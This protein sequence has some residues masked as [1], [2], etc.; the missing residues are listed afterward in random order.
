MKARNAAR[1]LL[2][3]F[4]SEERRGRPGATVQAAVQAARETTSDRAEQ[5]IVAVYAEL[6]AGEPRQ[7]LRL[8]EE[9]GV[10]ADATTARRIRA[11]RA[12]AERLDK[13]WYPG[14]AGGEFGPQGTA[15]FTLPSQ[16]FPGDS[17]TMLVE[18]C[19]ALGPA[20]L[21]S[22][23]S[24]LESLIRKSAPPA[25]ALLQSAL[26]DLQLFKEVALECNA[27][28]S[29][30]WAMQSQADLMH[31]CGNFVDAQQQLVRAREIYVAAG[32]GIGVACT[33]MVEGDWWATPGSSPE[34]LGLDLAGRPEPSPFSQSQDTARAAQAYDLAESALCASDTPRLAGALALRRA[35]LAF[36][37]GQLDEQRRW[38]RVADRAFLEA[39]ETCSRH[40][41][42]VHQLVGAVAEGDFV[43]LRR[44][45][46]PEWG[47][48]LGPIADVATWAVERGSISF[49]VGLGRILERTA[50]QW[51][52]KGDLDRAEIAYL[53]ARPLLP[54]SGVVPPWSVPMAL[55]ELDARRNVQ[56]RS[57][58]RRLRILA[59]LPPPSPSTEPIAWMQDLHLTMSLID[60]PTG[61]IGT[62]LIATQTIERGAQR[63][64]ALLETV[65]H[66]AADE[67]APRLDAEAMRAELQEAWDR[68]SPFEVRHPAGS[69]PEITR[70]ALATTARIGF[71]Q[72]ARARP[73]VS[74]LRALQA[75]RRGWDAEADLCYQTA[76]EEAESAG[77]ANRW[78]S[79]LVLAAWG[80][81]A[82]ARAVLS[83]I[84]DG[85][86]V[87]KTL[88]PSL[89][90]RA[91]DFETAKELFKVCDNQVP[92]GALNWID[93]LDRAEA[94][95]ECGEA[96]EARDLAMQSIES[97][98][99]AV[100]RLPRDPD[101]VA[102]CDDVKA[103]VLYLIASRAFLSLTDK[104]IECSDE[105]SRV[106]ALQKGF[107]IT[108]RGHA[109]AL[110][111]FAS[112]S[113]ST[114][115]PDNHQWK[116]WQQAATEQATA[117]QRFLEG[118]ALGAAESIENL[119]D[120]LS[121]AERRLAEVEADLDP[122]TRDVILGLHRPKDFS[123]A[124]AQSLIPAGV[125]LLEY[126]LV[127]RD[128][129][130]WGVT[131]SSVRGSYM[132]LSGR[133]LD[134]AVNR[135]LRSC[136]VGDPSAETAE[137]AQLLFEPFTELLDR[138]ERVIVVPFGVLHATPFHVLPF[139]GEPL[140]MTHIVSYLPAASL[141]IGRVIDR[142]L[143]SGGTLIVGDPDFD[144]ALYPTLR[145]LPGAALEG[146]I[147]GR[148][149]D[150][151]DVFTAADA[152]EAALRPLLRERAIVHFAAH[153]RL[154]ETAPNTSSIVLAGSDQLTV[155]DLIGLH[156]DAD[157]AVLSACDTGRGTVSLGGDVVGLTRGLLAAGVKRSVV[158]LW[159]VDDVAACLT[160]V[161]LHENL[162]GGDSPAMAL[163]RAQRG[164]RTM[165]GGELAERYRE[166]GGELA[167]GQVSKRR[168]S[169]EPR[170]N[171]HSLLG[172]EP[173]P[174]TDLD[175]KP[176][177]TVEESHGSLASIWAP[178]QLIGV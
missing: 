69:E 54:L 138:N 18:A 34:G 119:S 35:T 134:G 90:L 176:S 95:L 165:S 64:R 86:L 103:A 117:Y 123:L 38:L 77:G 114:F 7:A 153:G 58:V 141:L 65:S 112:A 79:V 132:R 83:H 147:L 53:M 118:L 27:P 143:G 164:V 173:F 66:S 17:E 82:K 67:A 73:Q 25:L 2:V 24:L 175:D 167:P 155:S 172:L 125:C 74:L 149:H 136:T 169:S 47:T 131:R 129:L 31:L 49:G 10:P 71:E 96:A 142:G 174:E 92:P 43:E 111:R 133:P 20:N 170:E 120:G 148:L 45:A 19:A 88:F 78:L 4:V 126:H 87:E 110:P 171:T 59:S 39:G 145:R 32:D 8:L 104:C 157:L 84:R 9:I 160:M 107:A 159:P 28:A 97:F 89:A 21:L 37:S 98:E 30:C 6:A 150:T 46:P 56:V 113:D 11:C 62:G 137:L 105:A 91:R 52:A 12:W 41:A 130:T 139:K 26:G 178:F 154:D 166:L 22:V 144:P 100:D 75:E 85:R 152:R 80:K 51:Q 140:G 23:R 168:K 146:A 36:L 162:L 40:L 13:N 108:D 102:A 115:R 55:A 156:I 60:I 68:D 122:K 163:A 72:L 33:H 99:A 158:S 76:F 14:N 124:D 15:G 151:R 1:E 5:L 135:L 127:G 3:S 94:A 121:I 44:L 42:F 109:L 177:R 50:E 106:D 70:I 63:L 116:Q 93:I 161:R 101:R 48:A 81:L 61:S 29:A 57:M 128:L 16:V